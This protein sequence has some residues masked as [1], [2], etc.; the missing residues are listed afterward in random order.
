MKSRANA[1]EV[2]RD[3]RR[4]VGRVVVL[5][6]GRAWHHDRRQSQQAREDEVRRRAAERRTDEPRL[7]EALLARLLH[8]RPLRLVELRARGGRALEASR[9]PSRGT[10][11]PRDIAYT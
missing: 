4:F 8:Q 7:A 5:V 9:L 2:E 11:S 1:G 6:V 3:L 10:P